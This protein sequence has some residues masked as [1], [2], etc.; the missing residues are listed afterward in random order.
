MAGRALKYQSGKF[1]VRPGRPL[2]ADLLSENLDALHAGAVNLQAHL[3]ILQKFG[4]PP[5][6]AINRFPTDTDREISELRKIA[7][8]SGATAVAVSNAFAQGGAGAE[9][10]ARAVIKA[11]KQPSQFRSLYSLDA[12]PEEKMTILAREIY[13]AD[14]VDI[15]PLAQE[16]L[17]RFTKLGFGHLPLCIAKTQYSLSHDPK[18]LGWPK[19][20]RFPIRD[21]RLAAGAGFLYALAGDISTMPGLPTNP[22]AL[23]IDLDSQGNIVGL[24]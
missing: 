12:L 1:D 22:A 14:N 16:K 4:V 7:F 17:A 13:G 23:R 6:V 10:L 2:P 24:T 18:R 21:V 11:T 3:A 15:A 5:V 20:Y 9:E 19:G 8:D